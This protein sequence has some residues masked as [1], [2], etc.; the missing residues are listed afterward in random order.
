MKKIN[1]NLS[2]IKLEGN[3]LEVAQSGNNVISKLI[4]KN[5]TEGLDNK[6]DKDYILWNRKS[7]DN[8]NDKYDIVCAF[9]SFNRVPKIWLKRLFKDIG[10]MLK[11]N[12]KIFIWDVYFPRIKFQNKL[13]I[14]VKI[15]ENDFEELDFKLYYNPFTSKFNDVVLNLEKNGYKIINSSICGN[16]YY[17]EGEKIQEG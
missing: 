5:S 12:G 13:C 7:L 6:I 17:I 1:I 2:D 8:K 3:V 9:F 15:G 16:I 4:E 11:N 10:L 14:R